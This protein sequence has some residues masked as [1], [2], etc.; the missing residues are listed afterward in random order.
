MRL[1]RTPRQAQLRPCVLSVEDDWQAP[2][3]RWKKSRYLWEVEASD[4]VLLLRGCEF[5]G[6]LALQI[7]PFPARS[8]SLDGDVAHLRHQPHPQLVEQSPVGIRFRIWSCQKPVAHEDRIGSREEAQG[9]SLL[10]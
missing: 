10:R 6:G 1:I 7:E 5:A 4:G 9:L 3:N 2:G 8:D